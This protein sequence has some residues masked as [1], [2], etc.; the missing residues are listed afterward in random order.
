MRNLLLDASAAGPRRLTSLGKLTLAAA[1]AGLLPLAPAVAQTAGYAQWSLKTNNQDSVALR[2]AGLTAAPATFSR[3][4]VSNGT[5][6]ASGTTAPAYSASRGQAFAPTAEGGGWVG[7][8]GGPGTNPQRGFYEE[9]TVTASAPTRLDSLLFTA[10]GA[11][12]PSGRVALQY[13]R[14]GFVSDSAN[15]SAGIGPAYAGYTSGTVTLP[16]SAGGPLP[17]TADGSFPATGATTT[18]PAVLPQFVSA[19][20]N[21]GVFRYAFNGTTGLVLA[22]GQKLTVRLYFAINNSNNGRYALLKDVTF[23]GRGA[24][25]SAGK[26]RLATALTAYP[27]PVAGTLEVLHSAAAAGAHVA[28]YS[29]TGQLVATAAAQPGAARTPLA[30]QQLPAGIYQVEYTDAT[31]RSTTRIVK[32]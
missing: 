13:S 14:S 12:S 32:Q 30:V 8:A 27:N 6:P 18:T 28:V 7:S 9:F 31:Q 1:V 29:V 22:A 5:V 23:K 21:S 20:G 16:T 10:A 19:N 4:V 26:A 15:F 11:S 2:S 24:V 17:A 25:L 3:Y